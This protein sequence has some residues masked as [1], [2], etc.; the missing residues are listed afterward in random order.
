MKGPRF[1]RVVV[2][3]IVLAWA[4]WAATSALAGPSTAR[5]GGHARFSGDVISCPSASI[6][7]AG[8]DDGKVGVL[9]D[10]TSGLFFPALVAGSIPGAGRFAQLACPSSSLCV[11]VDVNGALLSSTD[12]SAGAATWTVTRLPY[13]L[14]DALSCP[15]ALRCVAIADNGSV[16][17]S[18]QPAGGTS[19]WA[20]DQL[21]SALRVVS[22]PS[23]SLCVAID[24]NGHVITSADPTGGPAAWLPSNARA[25]GTGFG[26]LSCPDAS[27][28]VLGD[29]NGTVLTTR[30]PTTNAAWTAVHVDGR[31]R[32]VSI[33]CD[34]S[35]FCV[36]GDDRHGTVATRDP[37][38]GV[39]AWRRSVAFQE[40]TTYLR[41]ISCPAPS[42]CIATEGDGY[43]FTNNDP[44]TNARWTRFGLLPARHPH[45]PSRFRI[46]DTADHRPIGEAEPPSGSV[47]PTTAGFSTV[48]GG[49]VAPLLC[50]HLLGPTRKRGV[51]VATQSSCRLAHRRRGLSRLE[52]YRTVAEMHRLRRGKG[53]ERGSLA[54]AT[55]GST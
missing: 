33:T 30:S 35:A 13:R 28:C 14:S 16:V 7:F 10:P 49:L 38:S 29:V 4:T 3:L 43:G 32:I 19:A 6:C 15:S 54:G 21:T 25:L 1:V 31:A 12:P 11:G 24:V 42:F 8:G 55:K 53:S 5:P 36:A 48:A 39:S 34:A 45:R 51:D 52:T 17:T 26:G 37:T 9:S 47:P 2:V 18:G 20:A 50:P 44:I 40:N 23:V 41:S 22:C 46:K 27:L